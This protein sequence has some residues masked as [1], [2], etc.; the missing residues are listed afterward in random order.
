MLGLPRG[1]VVVA[2]PVA[3]ALRVPLDVLVVRKLGAPRQPELGFGAVAEGPTRVLNGALIAELGLTPAEVDAAA[4]REQAEV[5]RRVRRYRGERPPPDVRGRQVVLVD[6]GIA[7]GSTVRA[8]IGVLRAQGVGRVVVAAPVAAGEVAAGLTGL[9]DDVVVLRRPDRFCAI[10]FWYHDF[11]QVPDAQVVRL[12][13]EGGTMT[14]VRVEP[15]LKR[16]RVYLGGQVVADTLH[17]LLVWENPHYPAYYIP[18]EDVGATLTPTGAVEASPR[19]GDATV[20]DVATATGTAPGAARRYL[21]TPALAGSVRLAWDAM[22]EWLEEDEP[23]YTHPRDPRKRVDILASSRHVQVARDG[24]LLAD[25]RQPRIL[26][27]TDLPPRYY[28]PLTDVRMDLLRPSDKVT[29]CPYK[30]AASYYSVVV[31]DQVYPDLVWMYRA[32]LPESQ[33]IAGLACFFNERV[34]LTIDGVAVQRPRT[35]FS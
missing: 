25:S 18:A 2:A 20:Y 24:V 1:G 8:A 19:L 14:D 32:P 13:V 7:T 9:A 10:G 22:D 34:D 28:L 29:H 27:E 12:L 33:K 17:P 5:E 3:E 21:A 6:D 31:G 23:V 26:F 16:V 15:G 4:V 30:G 35:P 11:E